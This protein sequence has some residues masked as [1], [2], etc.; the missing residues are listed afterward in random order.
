MFASFLVIPIDAPIVLL[1]AIEAG[2]AVA[3]VFQ[4]PDNYYGKVIA[5][6]GDK[7]TVKQMADILTKHLSP[8]FVFHPSQVSFKKWF[9]LTST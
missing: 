2:K 1:S 7:I 5:F 6:A 4:H 9:Y 3:A 8:E